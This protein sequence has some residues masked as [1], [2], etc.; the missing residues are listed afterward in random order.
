MLPDIIS[1][2]EQMKHDELRDFIDYCEFI[3]LSKHV[4]IKDKERDRF[5]KSV[6]TR[7]AGLPEGGFPGP[8][9]QPD[10]KRLVMTTDLQ[11]DTLALIK[12]SKQ[13]DLEIVFGKASYQ[14]STSG[15][16]AWV[17][18]RAKAPVKRLSQGNIQIKWI[19]YKQLITKIDEKTGELVPALDEFGNRQYATIKAPYLY[20]RYWT[21]QGDS[22]RKKSRYKSIYIG[23]NTQFEYKR[24][25][26][27]IFRA[28][29]HHFHDLI[30]E[31]GKENKRTVT[32]KKT[33]E[34]KTQVFYMRPKTGA[35]NPIAE[36]ENKILDCVDMEAIERLK[37]DAID[38]DKLLE[39]QVIVCS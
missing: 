35:N 16:M 1:N 31:H 38:T 27:Y 13:A 26:E 24:Q 18:L 20:L 17:M 32:D 15:A 3:Y 9:L 23:G 19:P 14:R 4:S 37:K 22:D 5:I 7:R 21:V 29:A 11:R 33:G 10:A 34:I 8:L 12:Q 2:I 28:L 36:L 39:L 25:T 6:R 30:Q